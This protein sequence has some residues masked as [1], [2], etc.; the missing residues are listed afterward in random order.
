MRTQR[1]LADSSFIRINP[2][3]DRG[4]LEQFQAVEAPDPLSRLD[5]LPMVRAAVWIQNWNDLRTIAAVETTLAG[6][7]PG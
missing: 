1:R 4:W 6:E 3:S 2:P 5:R 7:S